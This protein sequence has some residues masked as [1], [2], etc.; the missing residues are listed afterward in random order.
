M[1]WEHLQDVWQKVHNRRVREHFRDL[2]PDPDDSS[3]WASFNDRL[4]IAIPRHSLYRACTITDN[5]TADMVSIRSFL[6]WV[7][8]GQAQA[9]HPPAYTIPSD[10]YQ[11]MVRF[12][13][14]VTMY[15]KEDLADVEESYAPI[16]AQISFRLMGEDFSSITRADLTLVA[17]KIRTEFA[18]NGGYRWQKGRTMMNYKKLED[19]YNLQVHAFSE[20]EGRRVINKILDIQNNTLDDSCLTINSLAATPPIVPPSRV[21]LGRSRRLP[22]KRPVGF[23]RFIYADCHVWGI[24]EAICLVDRSGRRKN[25]LIAV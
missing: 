12:S 1:S 7:V 9:M 16:D 23:V 21:I 18:L 22:R 25:P 3:G 17:E 8:L 24:P 20:N 10:R 6:F 11:Q 13:P 2:V 19:G 5:D 14:Q 4:D 15:F